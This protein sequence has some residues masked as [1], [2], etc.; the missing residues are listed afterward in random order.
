MLNLCIATIQALIAF[1]AIVHPTD[2][3]HRHV[4][5]PRKY[6]E[7]PADVSVAKTAPPSQN[8]VK[9]H[10]NETTALLQSSSTG[11]SRPEPQHASSEPHP[12][13][14]TT[15]WTPNVMKTMFA[16]FITSGHLG[17]FATLLAMLLSLP[18]VNLQVRHLPFQ[19]SRVL[20]L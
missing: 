2:I 8:L 10:V 20:G 5:E 13:P 7:L 11:S 1:T 6:L 4:L 18:F 3:F 17:T 16:Q 12:F 14:L 9:Q 15:T 19:F